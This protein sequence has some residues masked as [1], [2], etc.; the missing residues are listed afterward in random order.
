M[1]FGVIIASPCGSLENSIQK[2]F[3]IDILLNINYTKT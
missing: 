2:A 3:I 1:S